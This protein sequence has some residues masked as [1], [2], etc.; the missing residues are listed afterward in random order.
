MQAIV[1]KKQ[2]RH[3]KICEKV[4]STH[5]NC[6][7]LRRLRRVSIAALEACV[8]C[9]RKLRSNARRHENVART[10]R[11]AWQHAT[12]RLP[13]LAVGLTAIASGAVRGVRGERTEYESQFSTYDLGFL[14]DGGPPTP[15]RSG[16]VKSRRASVARAA[17]GRA[18]IN[19]QSQTQIAPIEAS[20]RFGIARGHT[21][22][23]QSSHATA[24]P[25]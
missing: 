1:N 18:P 15:H 21:A 13:A 7:I 24:G 16:G 10:A 11:R 23:R 19:H 8:L 2:F 6:Q 3:R 22:T 4:G 20:I 14:F 9:T 25:D 12:R 17:G 5:K